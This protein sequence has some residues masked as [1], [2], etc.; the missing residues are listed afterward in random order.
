MMDNRVADKLL[1]SM[2]VPPMAAVRRGIL[3][4]RPK[5]TSKLRRTAVMGGTPMVLLVILTGHAP[6]QEP[7]PTAAPSHVA[8]VNLRL[9]YENLQETIDTHQA[10]AAMQKELTAM[11]NPPD[12]MAVA[13]NLPADEHLRQVDEI[14]KKV[15]AFQSRQQ[16]LRV[17]IT[18]TQNRQLKRGLDQI[19]AAVA[20]IASQ[21]GLDLVVAKSGVIIPPA[22]ADD[23]DLRQ[24]DNAIF[25]R[26]ALYAAD[27][28]DITAEVIA[29]V[30]KNYKS[31][32]PPLPTLP[33]TSMRIGSKIFTLEIAADDASREHGLMERNTIAPDHGMI[34]VFP[35]A[36][37]Q[38]FWMHHTRFPLDII[39][40]DNHARVV[41]IS[42]MKAYDETGID[43]NGPS[44]YAIE[45][46]AG[47][48]AETGVKPGDQLTFPAVVDQSVKK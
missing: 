3:S 26:S 27:G 31:T 41:S 2:G 12:P 19:N 11:G 35:L 23:G 34:F 4:P 40:A 47:Q 9:A 45:L 24:M 28:V 13:K 15:M 29:A 21:R 22:I 20:A 36:E 39:Y 33:T 48:A 46:P 38:Q 32:A 43:S 18:R 16:Q 10:L 42:A 8:L 37:E 7:A 1:R 6:A 25:N 14:D 44:K 5:W 30:N 17:E